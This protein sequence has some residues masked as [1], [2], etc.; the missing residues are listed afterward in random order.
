MLTYKDFVRQ[1]TYAH[2]CSRMLTYADVCS[3]MQHRLALESPQVSLALHHWIDLVFG[4][5]L[6]GE[7]ALQAKNVLTYSDVC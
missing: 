6:Q 2:V 4:Y 7:A 5:K 1:V 3:R